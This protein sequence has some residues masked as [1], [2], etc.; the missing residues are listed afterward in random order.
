MFFG[1]FSSAQT[2]DSNPT[3]YVWK[4]KRT[5]SQKGYVVLKSG[6][7]LEGKISLRGSQSAIKSI[8]FNGEKEID[9]PLS[10]LTSYGLAVSSSNT[11]NQEGG[12]SSNSGPICDHN[13]ELF[14]WRD[15]GEQMEKQIHNT[16][17]RN[18]YVILRDGSR[19]EGELQLKKVDGVMTEIKL[20]AA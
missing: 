2:N 5:V 12:S 3:D 8:P 6:K 15:M 10:A 19:M 17:P 7:K 9:F 1:T 4:G 20:K 11:S 13:P 14:T 16:K 18:G